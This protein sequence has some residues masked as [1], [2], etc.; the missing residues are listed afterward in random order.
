MLAWGSNG[1][2]QQASSDMGSG[3]LVVLHVGLVGEASHDVA[4][5]QPAL[6][7]HAVTG[8]HYLGVAAALPQLCELAHQP[9]SNAA[10]KQHKSQSHTAS[11]RNAVLPLSR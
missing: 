4:H 5:A 1:F 3:C 8:A 7:Q 11:G 2:L 6:A 10:H 9:P